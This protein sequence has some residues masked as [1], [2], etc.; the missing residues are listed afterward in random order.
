MAS[1]QT[2]AAA[3]RIDLRPAT[4][5]IGLLP[6]AFT[7]YLGLTDGLGADPMRT[8]EQ[9][10]GLWA[11]RFLVACLAITP[12]RRIGGPNL[13]VYRRAVGLLAFYYALM[14]LSVYLA[15]DQGFDLQAIAADIVKRPFITIGMLAFAL[16]VPLALTSTNTMMRRLG[17]AA[18]RKLHRLVYI[19]GAAAAVHFIMVVKSW[20]AEPL[21]Y[22]ALVA[23]L[24]L[25]R[26]I[27]GWRRGRR[28]AH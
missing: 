8:L 15:L 7:L 20:P 6:A 24:L 14:H 17:G 1:A 18:W 25:F 22:A 3:R 21:V 5:V 10:L 23:G 26:V 19:A 9:T 11:L 16:L 4:Y 27:D 2:T 13:V 12:L 28:A